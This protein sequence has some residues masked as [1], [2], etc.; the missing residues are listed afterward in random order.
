[1]NKKSSKQKDSKAILEKLIDQARQSLQSTVKYTASWL[2][3]GGIGSPSWKVVGSN[4][5]IEIINFEQPLA[6]LT[7]LTAPENKL[8]LESIQK[9][10]FC[11]RSGLL[12]SRVCYQVWLDHIRAYIN[13]ASWLSLYESQYQPQKYGFKLLNENACKIIIDGYSKGGWAGALEFKDRISAHLCEITEEPYDGLDLTQSNITKVCE[14][15]K[16]NNL[17]IS[18]GSDAL[19]ESGLVSRKY[20]AKILGT[21]P[22]AFQHV[23]IRDFLRQFEPPLQ[24]NILSAGKSRRGNYNSHRAVLTGQTE[25]NTVTKNTLARFIGFLKSLDAGSQ[26]LPDLMPSFELDTKQNLDNTKHRKGGHTQKIPHSIGMYALEKSIEWIMVYGRPI[27]Q[28]TTAIVKAINN[29]EFIKNTPERYL[30][31]ERQRVFESIAASYYTVA[32]NGLPARSLTESLGLTK[33]TSNSAKACNNKNMTLMVALECLISSFAIVIGLTKPI[34]VAELAKIARRSLSADSDGGGAFLSHPSLK[35]GLSTTPDIRRP[36]P[37]VTSV[38]VQLLAV[39]GNNLKAIYQ[40]DSPHSEDLF[41]FPSAKG[42]R[43]PGGI[44]TSVRIDSAIKTFCDIIEIPTD[45]HGRRW[46]IKIHEMRKFFILTMSRHERIFTDDALRHQ[47]G[48]ADKRHLEAYLGG[49]IPDEEVIQ[50]TIESIEDKLIDLELGNVD[51]HSNQGL[52]ALYKNTL[53]SL[54]I[55]SLKSKNQYDFN[56]FIRAL[57]LN[58]NLSIVTYTIRLTTYAS[59]VI[60]TDI[61]IKYGES[62]DEKFDN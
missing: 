41:Y 62:K 47:A 2:L 27:V 53:K 33:L 37:Y 8:L 39:L 38:A 13:T 50:Y 22:S 55:S 35:K 26:I 12:H 48:H 42:F 49:D 5:K 40:D 1:M 7:I 36:I 17:Y 24:S 32:F 4:K 6:N 34:R 58:E 61:A 15:L 10:A 20:L 45:Q 57:L 60:D 14:Y 28:L 52:S 3:E 29:P 18:S 44:K 25:T 46:Y 9:Q 19:S 30:N 16:T 23:S 21:H 59:E 43:C 31:R 11:L 51:E 56:Q 54:K